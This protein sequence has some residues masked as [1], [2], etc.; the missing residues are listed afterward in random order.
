MSKRNNRTMDFLKRY[1]TWDRARLLDRQKNERPLWY[2]L[3]LVLL[4]YLVAFI[5][6]LIVLS[7]LD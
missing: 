1:N 7:Y 4:V 5:V 2:E 6:I 3:G